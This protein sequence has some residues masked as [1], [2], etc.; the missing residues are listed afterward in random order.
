M[1]SRWRLVRAR[2]DAVPASVRRFSGRVRRRRLR[3]A[4]PWLV[5]LG[6][7]ALLVAAAGLAYATPL[8]GVDEIR[9]SGTRTVT[10]AEVRAAAQVR[11]G[12][13]L[14]RVDVDA[15]SRQVGTL[16]AVSRAT[17]VRR[18]PRALVVRVVERTPVAVVPN[19]DGYAIVDHTGVVFGWQA[20][21]PASLPVLKVNDPDGA[22]PATRAALAVLGV[23]PAQLK[24][25]LAALTAETPARV[26]LELSD[27]RQIIW[28][29]AT[30]DDAKVRVALALLSGDQ[31]V[32]D[33]SA[34]SV[35]PTR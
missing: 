30:Q 21:R 25:R 15:V 12:T 4:L 26:R 11:R 9:V 7:V 32:M 27:G 35:I 2:R 18:W 19:G 6:V 14:L 22:D 1:S 29:D 31:K 33:V 13:P 8:L 34:P 17:V 20:R 16:P 24:D 28:G 3:A 5:A 23:L 10:P